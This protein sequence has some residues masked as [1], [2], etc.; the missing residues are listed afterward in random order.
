MPEK[1]DKDEEGE[2]SMDIWCDIAATAIKKMMMMMMM[3]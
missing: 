1:E 2:F 3:M